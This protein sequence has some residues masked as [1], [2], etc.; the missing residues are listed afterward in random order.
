MRAIR[1]VF[2][3]IISIIALLI[4]SIIVLTL[5]LDPNDYKGEIEVL[6]KEKGGINLSID[7]DI[8]W[9]L[10][11]WLGLSV[12]NTELKTVDNQSF[13]KI[14]E[15]QARVS[16]ASLFEMKPQVQ[17]LVL[18]G[19][20]LNLHKDS[21]GNA[22]WEKISDKPEE[23]VSIPEETT[24][25]PTPSAN[26]PAETSQ[27]DIQ[28]AVDEVAITN[29]K[30]NYVDEQSGQS[31]EVAPLNILANNISLANYFPLNIDFQLKDN[32]AELSV[33]SE[34]TTQIRL[35][36]GFQSAEL[37][38]LVA[39]T[40]LSGKPFNNQ[41][42]ESTLAADI[43]ADLANKK[44]NLSNF[45]A[46]LGDLKLHAN[47]IADTRSEHPKLEGTIEAQPFSLQKLL[48][49]LGQPAI[50][51]ADPAV[52]KE[53]SFKTTLNSP[54]GQLALQNTQIVLDDTKFTGNIAHHWAT[55]HIDAQLK[56]DS[57]DV[58]RYLPPKVL[59]ERE[60]AIQSL[61]T[62]AKVIRQGEE[63]PLEAIDAA[64]HAKSTIQQE[65]SKSEP[66]SAPPA[67][68]KPVD[69]NAPLLPLET[70]K[71]LSLNA[72]FDLQQLTIQKL[73]IQNITIGLTA[74]DGLITMN[75]ANG[76]LYDGNFKANATIDARSDKVTWKAHKEIN[77]IQ[78]HPLL[79]TLAELGILSGGI[80]F[81]ADF[82]SQGNSIAALKK[83]TKG[84]ASFFL[85]EGALNGFNLTEEVCKG[86]SK[87]SKKSITK[88][89]WEK[90]TAFSD[91]SGNIAINGLNLGN[92]S[93]VGSLAGVK[94]TGKGDISIENQALDYQVALT[95]V[96]DEAVK[97]CNINE[98]F[99]DIPWPIRCKGSFDTNPADLC[100]PDMKAFGKAVEKLA[101]KEVK[102]KVNKEVDKLFDK[103]SDKLDDKTKNSL[104][105]VLKGLF[106]K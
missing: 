72:G 46:T 5:V 2:I 6:A 15:L 79:Q 32:K 91:L 59:T 82:N 51:T 52:L 40:L 45:I 70:I 78:S 105:G 93:L 57:I 13:T 14:N 98:K 55:G 65:L 22:N 18:D 21:E 85:K 94:L 97:A 62:D 29:L 17:K 83:S 16:L 10:Y 24:D 39:T 86:I 60:L 9:S 31:I 76:E 102:R 8:E 75:K 90:K 101:K 42:I 41:S 64:G 67:P 47:L 56:G 26:E 23:T 88:T 11:P 74:S 54:E 89:D 37:K 100:R 27:Q 35:G 50:S 38:D 33:K 3:T 44:F 25:K 63:K 73:P 7:G 19:L 48:T 43:I 95:I 4:G 53:I 106:N 80:N 68:I 20:E 12:G 99:K 28:F 103:H 49:Q 34:L 58:D 69:E 96:G 84:N 71:A 66:P 81:K 92:P 30:V 61:K 104:K 87:V 77:N 1:L 36:E